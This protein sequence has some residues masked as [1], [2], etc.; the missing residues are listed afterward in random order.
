MAS[1][2]YHSSEL[3]QIQQKPDSPFGMAFLRVPTIHVSVPRSE[4]ASTRTCDESTLDGKS[5][6]DCVD[7]DD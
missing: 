4:E 6:L 5:V 3:E 7:D 2:T 1:E